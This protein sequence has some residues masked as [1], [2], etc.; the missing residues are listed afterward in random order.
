MYQCESPTHFDTDMSLD[1]VFTYQ[2]QTIS[3][4][5]Q[6]QCFPEGCFSLY[7]FRITGFQRPRAISLRPL[8]PNLLLLSVFAFDV[9]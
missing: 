1:N 3:I 6:Q 7:N 5:P 9:E 8:A 4:A 2:I